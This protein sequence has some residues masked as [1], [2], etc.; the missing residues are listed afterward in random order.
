M[1]FINDTSETGCTMAALLPACAACGSE[2]AD[3]RAVGINVDRLAAPQTEHHPIS[4]SGIPRCR[5][6]NNWRLLVLIDARCNTLAGLPDGFSRVCC[7]GHACH[8]MQGTGNS[9]YG[10]G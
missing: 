6:K 10:D 2:Q 1:R 5:H 4:G 7:Y 3:Q 8:C 9:L